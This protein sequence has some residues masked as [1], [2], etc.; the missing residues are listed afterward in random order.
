MLRFL[1]ACII[2]SLFT[3]TLAAQ[4]SFPSFPPKDVTAAMDR[5]QMLHQLGMELPALPPRR[6]DPNA[7]KNAAPADSTKPEGNWKDAYGHIITRSGWG[8]WNNYDDRADGFFPGKDSQRVGRYTPIDLLKNK[9]GRI[10]TTPREW[11]NGR[12]AEILKDAQELLYGVIPPDSILPAVQFSVT[13]HA[14]GQGDAAYIQKEIFG[15]IDISRYPAVRDTPIIAAV[16]RIPATATQPVPVMIVYSGFGNNLETYWNRTVPNGWGVCTFNPNLLQPDNGAGLTSFLIGLVN[17]GNW[18]KPSDWGTIG[19]WSWGISRLID[20]LVTD[21]QLNPKM[22]GLTGHSRYGKATL[23]TM[24][25]DQ[26][27][28]IGFPSDA[29]SLGTKMNR[30]HWG[31]DLENSTGPSEYHWMAG[32]FFQWAGELVPGQYLPRKIE[33]CPVDAHSLLALCAPRPV[34]INAGTRSTWTDPYG[35]YLTT[36]YASPVYQLLGKK[37]MIMTDEKPQIDAAYITGEIGFRYH[38]GGH[39]DAPDWP[40][41]FEFAAKY[42]KTEKQ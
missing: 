23:V 39:T 38:E 10:I 15:A 26:R 34:F 13:T 18:R 14:G 3:S 24:G 41:F 1:S 2:L 35:M 5:N 7:P 31:Q 8:L 11:W 20:Y 16:L 40:A 12:R 29:G 9:N 33:R 17:K 21:K 36:V 42:F 22:I 19:A 30:R 32:T 4:Q 27:I 37:G 28:A 25:Y 6:Q